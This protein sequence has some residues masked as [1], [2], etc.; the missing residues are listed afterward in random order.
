MHSSSHRTFC[1]RPFIQVHSVE[2]DTEDAADVFASRKMQ[3]LGCCPHSVSSAGNYTSLKFLLDL[4]LSVPP[5]CLGD[6]ESNLS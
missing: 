3:I 1:I 4:I 6:R 2:E 5:G